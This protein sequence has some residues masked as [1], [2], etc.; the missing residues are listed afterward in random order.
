M[1]QTGVKYKVCN[2]V[3]LSQK[4]SL[5]RKKLDIVYPVVLFT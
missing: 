4:Y 1:K 3:V 5:K 2:N